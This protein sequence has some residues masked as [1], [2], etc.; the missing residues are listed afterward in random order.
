MNVR[1]IEAVRITEEVK[2]LCIRANTVLRQDVLLA[3]KRLY[4]EETRPQAKEMLA[5]LIEN[6]K[7]AENEKLAICQDTGIVSVF[8][9]IG[10]EVVIQ[11]MSVGD[12][13]NRGVAS[14]YQEAYLR[15]SVVKDP[16]LRS[17]TGTNTPAVI[18]T[19]V[20]MGREIVISVLPKGFGSENTSR[21]TMLNP[22]AG[23]DTIKDF[24]VETVRLAGPD[25]CPP[26]ILGI[27][28][29]GTVEACTLLAKKALLRSIGLPNR[30]PHVAELE[31]AIK[32]K[33]NTLG[34]GIMGLGGISTVMGVN[35]EVGPTHI[36]GLPVSVIVSCHALRS[37]TG[38]I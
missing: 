17:N 12:A 27:G 16:L 8:I 20:I 22:T 29:G 34:I 2:R 36:A 7:I 5:V 19:N 6:A 11:G 24:C 4:E 23:L 10:Q 33:A 31:D 37:A 30:L 21:L 26:Y 15:K 38:R 13:V 28:I 1:R 14:A 32:K 35:I 25:A 3:I 18:H 9:D